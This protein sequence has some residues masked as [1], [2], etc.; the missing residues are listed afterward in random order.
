MLP[1]R[2]TQFCG[3]VRAVEWQAW[4]GEHAPDLLESL[5]I[6]L[7]SGKGC[8]ANKERMLAIREVLYA[9]GLGER[10]EQFVIHRYP[11]L[12]AREDPQAPACVRQPRQDIFP[13]LPIPLASRN[14]KLNKHGVF[15]AY[16]PE[17]LS[18]PH[19]L[20]IQHQNRDELQKQVADFTKR[21]VG[22][23]VITIDDTAYIEYVLPKFAD[24]AAKLPE[25]MYETKMFQKP[26]Q[27]PATSH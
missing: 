10:F 14:P 22:V 15:K 6:F 8:R 2:E 3:L 11:L 23:S 24:V 17:L 27:K 4:L 19:K 13:V 12:V 1:L 20:I 9:R 5:R 21:M 26:T 7:K 16:R 25:K 18:F